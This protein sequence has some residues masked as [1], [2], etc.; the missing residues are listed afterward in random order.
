MSNHFFV[1]PCFN[2]PF[3]E[4]IQ[5]IDHLHHPALLVPLAKGL[6]A[7]LGNDS[8]AS[9]NHGGLQAKKNKILG[10][11]SCNKGYLKALHVFKMRCMSIFSSRSGDI[12]FTFPSSVK[13]LFKI[14]SKSK[15]FSKNI[16]ISA[17]NYVCLLTIYH[18]PYVCL[19]FRKLLLGF[20]IS[21]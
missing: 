7:H 13:V 14:Y 12:D 2:D 11:I 19:S 21:S 20:K 9:T 18:F 5:V 1:F 4:L 15:N 17:Y 8:N 3:D 10:H 6:I 16:S